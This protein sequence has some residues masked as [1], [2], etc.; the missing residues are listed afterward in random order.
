MNIQSLLKQAQK[1]QK[2]LEAI[3]KELENK[4][5]CR[6]RKSRRCECIVQWRNADPITDDQRRADSRRR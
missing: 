6:N 2:E 3:E 5:I 1:M 4:R